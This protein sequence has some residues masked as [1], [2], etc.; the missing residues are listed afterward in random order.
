M[1]IRSPWREFERR[2]G[3][4]RGRARDKADQKGSANSFYS[5]HFPPGDWVAWL[6]RTGEP[7][8][9][10]Q[11]FLMTFSPIVRG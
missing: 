7:S 5:A 2:P 11:N 8:P 1:V 4:R 9:A 6:P 3:L 10:A